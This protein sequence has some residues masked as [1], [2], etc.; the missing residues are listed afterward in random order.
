MIGHDGLADV[1][2]FRRAIADRMDAEQLVCLVVKEE[3]QHADV[4]ADD[5]PS[6]DLPVAGDTDGIGDSILRELVF[7]AADHGNFG[8]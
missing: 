7:V 3:L 5:L 8:N 1:N 2:E 6:G 4:I